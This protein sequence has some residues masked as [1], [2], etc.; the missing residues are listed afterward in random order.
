MPVL[1]VCSAA[2]TTPTRQL[3]SGVKRP[4]V[5][6]VVHWLR[7]VS[8]QPVQRAKL[9]KAEATHNE[10]AMRAWNRQLRHAA[11]AGGAAGASAIALAE[12]RSPPSRMPPPSPLS[13]RAAAA[14]AR[15]VAS[16]EPEPPPSDPAT[17]KLSPPPP[18]PLSPRGAAAKGR[19]KPPAVEPA[20]DTSPVARRSKDA[21][22][23]PGCEAAAVPPPYAELRS[24]HTK[25]AA[26]A[27]PGGAAAVAQP[28]TRLRA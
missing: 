6:E 20:A 14:R 28:Q 8:R 1:H 27:A 15:A 18:L 2:S 10:S 11:A 21:E 22:H 5:R 9:F 24:R 7:A 25:P 26:P 13:P 23:A 4:R 17:V 16:A 12:P 3:H 19:S